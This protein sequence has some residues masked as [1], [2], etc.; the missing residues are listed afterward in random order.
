[1]KLRGTILRAVQG[2]LAAGSIIMAASS[3][4]HGAEQAG[5]LQQSCWTPAQLAGRPEEKSSR[6]QPRAL[7]LPAIAPAATPNPVIGNVRRVKLPPGKKL[8][9]LTFDLCEAAWEISGYDGGVIDY[10]RA[11]QVKATLFVGGKWMVHHGERA[12]QLMADPLFEIGTHGWSHAN[13]HTLS[14]PPI[15]DEVFAAVSA[16]KMVRRDLA[17]H[18]CT[19]DS[20]ELARIP[21]VPKLFRFPFGTCNP[22]ALASVSRSGQIA[23]QWDVVTGDPD[24]HVTANGIAQ[25]VLRETRPGSI[26][27]AH[28][29]GRGARTAEALPLFVP[30]LKAKGFEFVTVSELLAAGTPEIAST[31]YER[32]PGDNA[33][34][35]IVAARPP[36]GVQPH[37]TPQ[38]AA[39]AA[40]ARTAP[41]PAPRRK[42]PAASGS[43]PVQVEGGP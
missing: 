23:I 18:E 12:E 10:L 27:V 24:R 34:Y 38:P 3:T 16:Y 32:R 15:D 20:P 2:M 29:N 28:A 4:A 8:V 31:C 13:L 1:M 39:S 30:Q 6:P 19:R 21:A 40:P 17:T 26:I 36:R 41:A 22:E 5:A 35:D 37:G 9:A 7:A 11:N 42:A 14:G 43:W 25:A 33:R